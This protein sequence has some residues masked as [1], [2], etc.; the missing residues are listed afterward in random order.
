MKGMKTSA[1]IDRTGSTSDLHLDLPEDAPKVYRALFDQL[2]D[3]FAQLST[4]VPDEPM[5]VGGS[6]TTTQTIDLLGADVDTTVTYTL[7]SMDESS[8]TV[9]AVTKMDAEDGQDIMA[10]GQAGTLDAFRGAG[11]GESTV[12]I[13]QRV[14]EGQGQ[15]SSDQTFTIDGQT[16]R[17]K[18]R[19]TY[20]MRLI[21]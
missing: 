3:M 20:R 9:R 5:G 21:P 7:T 15:S 16:L 1:I 12:R 17:Q 2:E 14:A 13:G 18:T 19:A 4:P 10:S 6:W 8:Y 11:S